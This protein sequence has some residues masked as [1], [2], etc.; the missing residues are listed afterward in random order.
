[1]ASPKGTPC[2]F[3]CHPSC[4]RTSCRDRREAPSRGQ[5][6]LVVGAGGGDAGD[7]AAHARNLFA[8]VLVVLE[9]DVVDDLCDRAKRRIGQ[10]RM[11]D[12]DLEGAAV[13]LV[14]ELALE[15]VEAQ[16]ARSGRITLARHELE[17]RAAVDEAPYQPG[18]GDAVDLHAL[19]RHP[20]AV[21][22][23]CPGG[24]AR[25]AVGHGGILLFERGLEAR[26]EALDRLASLGAEEID[27]NDRI[28]LLAQPAVWL[29]I[30]AKASSDG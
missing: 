28:E 7:Q 22:E 11:V 5:P 29:A 15:H 30:S 14:R 6:L 12:Q 27:G 17:T 3:I 9:I 13:A 2:S 19:A 23:S 25:L 24:Y 16:L 4:P 1:M 26:D 21:R 8:A 10:A 18:R 20:G